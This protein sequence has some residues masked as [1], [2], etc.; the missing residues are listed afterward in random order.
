MLCGNVLLYGDSIISIAQ[1]KMCVLHYNDE[2][3]S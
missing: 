2:L 3:I 1:S